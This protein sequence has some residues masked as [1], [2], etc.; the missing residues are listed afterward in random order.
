MTAAPY[1]LIVGLDRADKKADLCL[2]DTA[3]G[4]RRTGPGQRA[5]DTAHRVACQYFES[6]GALVPDAGALPE[7]S[8]PQSAEDL[9]PHT[10][11]ALSRQR[12]AQTAEGRFAQTVLP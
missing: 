12:F 9:C 1:D 6:L 4:Q 7:I 11:E 8:P 3:T 2:I 5:L 10:V